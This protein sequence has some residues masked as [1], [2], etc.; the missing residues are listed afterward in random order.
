MRAIRSKLTRWSRSPTSPQRAPQAS[1]HDSPPS[2]DHT[3]APVMHADLTTGAVT[4]SSLGLA[5]FRSLPQSG[6]WEQKGALETA[7]NRADAGGRLPL[8]QDLVRLHLA[9][10]LGRE[11]KAQL[12]AMQPLRQRSGLP[13]AAV[14]ADLALQGVASFLTGQLDEAL[15]QLGDA[16]LAADDETALWH[17]ATLAELERWDDALDQWQRGQRLLDAYPPETR[18]VLAERGIMLLLQTG[19]IDDAFALIDG[20]RSLLLST[21]AGERIDHFEALALARDGA[22]EEAEAIWSRLAQRRRA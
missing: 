13:D 14:T 4:P 10:G 18:A 11:A 21:A 22:T 8:R 1:S 16:R 20:L 7:I 2:D 19:R 17:A 15:A 12:D 9:H 6:F 5:R 3:D